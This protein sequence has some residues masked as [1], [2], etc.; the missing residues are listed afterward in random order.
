MPGDLRLISVLLCV[1]LSACPAAAPSTDTAADE[2]AIRA[3]VDG[4]NTALGAQN[5]SLVAATFAEDAL[6]MPPGGPRVSGRANIRAMFAAIWPLKASLNFVPGTI[7]IEGDLAVEEGTWVWSMPGPHGPVND[8]GNLLV[9]WQ[10]TDTSWE[11]TQDI[12]NSTL[13]PARTK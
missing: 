5:D 4:M 7:R 8:N 13:P 3:L 9:V 1:T 10:R 11:V 6:L 12:W 2:Q